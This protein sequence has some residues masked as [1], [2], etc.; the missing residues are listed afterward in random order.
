[1]TKIEFNIKDYLLIVGIVLLLLVGV[2]TI[3]YYFK[4]IK[5]ECINEPFVFGAK[6]ME[7][8]TTGYFSGYGNLK[9]NKDMVVAT[10]V[11]NSS[12]FEQVNLNN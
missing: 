9:N 2:F 11:F 5:D 4:A 1:M 12:E 6:Q 8:T 10:F 7:D 3:E